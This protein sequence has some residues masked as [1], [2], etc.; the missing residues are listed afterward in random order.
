M[1]A[2]QG[3]ACALIGA[4]S[5]LPNPRYGADTGFASVYLAEVLYESDAL[6]EAQRLLTLY[7]PLVKDAGIPDQLASSHIVYARIL[8][9]QGK[10]TAA[11]QILLELEQLGM[12]RRLTRIADMSRLEQARAMLLDGELDAA[13]SML[14]LI[15][16]TPAWQR[17]DLQMVSNDM[18]TQ[19]LGHMRLQLHGGQAAATL[20]PLKEH[21]QDAY[22]RGR[23]RYALRVKVLYALA[24]S[25]AGQRNPALRTIR[26]TLADALVEGFVRPFKDEGPLLLGLVRDMLDGMKDLASHDN[27]GLRMFAELLVAATPVR[28]QHMHDMP[29]TQPSAPALNGESDLTTREHD[30]L[31]LLAQGCGNQAIAEKLFISVTTVKTHLRNINLKLGA[32]NRTEAISLARKLGII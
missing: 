15:S 23:M 26:E 4:A 28:S 3:R 29:A 11:L 25:Q 27:E 6:D 10:P 24:L 14:A 8:R 1:C 12:Q 2:A 17:R 20:A 32:H 31:S 9:A 22:A 18:E 7:L 21:L 16:P 19:F 13:R 30:V 5:E